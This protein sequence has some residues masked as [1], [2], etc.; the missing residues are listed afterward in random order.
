MKQSG[1]QRIHAPRNAVWQA[2]NDTSVLRHC[3]DGCESFEQTA[4]GRFK[5]KV[6]A[7]IGPVNA[8]F[9]ADVTLAEEPSSSPNAQRFRLQVELERASA[10]F[11]KGEAE[12]TLTDEPGQATLLT[13]EIN[14]VVGGK[15]AQVGARLIDAAAGA[16]ASA[17]FS[18]LEATLTGKATPKRTSTAPR[19]WLPWGAAAVV[20]T[21]LILSVLAFF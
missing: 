19:A 17:F 18:E 1:R 15:L 11:G 16:M 6:R 14:A 2:L 8:M 7:R 4:P 13:Y 9:A 21:A 5:A 12:V 20:L 10:G 3:I